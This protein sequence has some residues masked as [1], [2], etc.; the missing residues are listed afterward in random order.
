MKKQIY[1]LGVFTLKQENH[2][3]PTTI[4]NKNIYK[5]LLSKPTK[6]TEERAYTRV[7]IITNGEKFQASMYTEKQVFHENLKNE[8]VK[9]FVD[10]LFGSR[11]Q[12]YTAWDMEKE[13]SARYTKKGKILTSSKKNINPLKVEKFAAGGFNKQKNHII[14][15]GEAVPALVDMGVFTKDYKVAASMYD[16]FQQINRFIE[17]IDDETKEEKLKGCD[18]INII[19]FGCGKSYLTFLVY[20]YFKEIRKYPVNICGMDLDASIVETCTKAAQKYGYNSLFFMQG[21]IGKQTAPPVSNWGKPKTFN[22]V[23][24][25]HACDTA[26][27]YAIYNAIKWQADLICAV[28]CCQHQLRNQMKPK[29]LDI[30]NEYGIIK[31]RIASLATDAIRAKLLEW[32]GYRVQIIEF[33]SMEHTP[34][35]LFIR[36]RWVE[37]KNDNALL[38]VERI[39]DEFGFKPLL[40]ELLS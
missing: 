6:N 38:A 20:H 28:P 36:A 40:L 15:E 21:D 35:N 33:T 23:I 14:K 18:Q 34:K 5:I 9:N 26:T 37:M 1:K 27:D 16:K 8:D 11:F 39:L 32:M 17:L 30:L 31:E 25:L 24:S 3:I 2:G 19:D 10:A 29:N 4:F 7:E 13:Y 22:I 12:Q